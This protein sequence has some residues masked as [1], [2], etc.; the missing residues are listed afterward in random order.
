MLRKMG[1]STTGLVAIVG[2]VFAAAILAIGALSYRVTHEA[3][4]QQLNHRIAAETAGLLAEAQRRGVPA[5]AAAITR[6]E[7]ARSTASLDYLLVD[8]A[9]RHMAG[10]LRAKVPAKA[11]FEEFLHYRKPGQDEPAIAQALTTKVAGGTLVVAADRASLDEI[12]RT[13]AILFAGALAAMLAVGTLA[14]GIIGGLTQRRLNSI[15]ATAQAIISG[16]LARRVPRDGSGSEF[17][18]LAG[19]LNTMLNRIEALMDNLRQVSS[20]V[21]HD[22]RTPLTRLC[23]SLDLAAGEHHESQRAAHLEIARRQAAELLEIFAALLRIAEIEGMN[24]RLPRQ[25]LDLTALLEKMA[26]S[27]APDFE[28]SGRILNCSI[29]P[30]LWVEGDHRL[31]SQ[32]MANLLDNGL[33]H[34]PPGTTLA[35]RA[36]PSSGGIAI[37]VG[38]DGPGVPPMDRDRLFNRFARAEQARSTAGHGLG[39]SMVKAIAEAH[40]GNV[41]ILDEPGFV[42]ELHLPRDA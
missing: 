14:A 8:D 6:R 3:L 40:G 17:D 30:D 24:E 20:D 34:T 18:R 32:V 36:G 42:V 25:R 23:G 15:D 35:L 4:E 12:D 19:T 37:V 1:R 27:Y 31:L 7:A 38:D 2:I 9:G 29:A 28:D 16:D 11:G 22:L 39:L 41:S 26:E 10:S 33:S 13:L 21:A 5:I